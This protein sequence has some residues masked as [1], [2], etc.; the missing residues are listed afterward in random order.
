M[1]KVAITGNIASGKSVIE[2]ILKEKNFPVLDCDDVVHE[3]YKEDIIKK[4]IITAFFGFDILEDGNISRQKL[5]KIVF[6]NEP[7]RKK[8]EGIIY[9]YVKKEIWRFFGQNESGKIAFVSVPLL[10]ESGFEALFD[11][12]ILVYADDKT[13]LERLIKR[14][15][16]VPEQAQNRINIQMSQDEKIKL[17]DYV[18]YNNSSLKDLTGEVE[19]TLIYLIKNSTMPESK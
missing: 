3:L 16:L 14:S 15:N 7:F 1:I 10:F 13:R 11:K 4:Q 19:K 9:P 8:L 12:V 2:E 6:D 17:A 5:G 18:I